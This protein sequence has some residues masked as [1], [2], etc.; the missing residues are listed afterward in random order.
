MGATGAARAQETPYL[1]L[2]NSGTSTATVI[3]PGGNQPLRLVNV[4]VTSDLSTSRLAWAY[5]T[6]SSS[7]STGTNG[8]STNALVIGATALTN[9]DSVLL[10]TAAGL[11]T[12]ATVHSRTYLANATVYLGNVLGTNLAFGDTFQ[13]RL[14]TAFT[15]IAPAA[16]NSTSFLINSTNGLGSTDIV[17]AEFNGGIWTATNSAIATASRSFLTLRGSVQTPLAVGDLLYERAT[18]FAN[19][20]S[21]LT[22]SATNIFVETTNGFASN[23]VVVVET[24]S[25]DRAVRVI[26]TVAETN[27]ILSTNAGFALAAN[28]R[29]NIMLNQKSVRL[30]ASPGDRSVII[31]GSAGLALDDDVVFIPTTGAPWRDRV[32][33]ALTATNINTLTTAAGSAFAL[34]VGASFYKLTNYYTLTATASRSDFQVSVGSSSGL[35]AADIV[36]L[37]PASGGVFKNFVLGTDTNVIS[38]VNFTTAIGNPLAAGDNIWLL[39]PGVSTPVGAAT[40]RIANDATFVAPAGRPARLQLTGTSACSINSAVGKYAP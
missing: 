15:L 20:T 28:D 33:A 4:D 1:T 37:S 17:V 36:I 27:L 5:G 11:V 26:Y 13:E 30:P 40:L 19:L 22:S 7:L 34:P 32:G 3:F 29:I 39:G 31:S 24:T 25:G 21:T 35:V 10:Q 38:R 6:V 16:S 2:T 12:N 9:N 8:A 18:N 14:P 23:D